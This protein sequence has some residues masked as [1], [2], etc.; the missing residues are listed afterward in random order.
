MAKIT[1]V[2]P[3]QAHMSGGTQLVVTGSGFT[4]VSRVFFEDRNFRQY[5]AQFTVDSTTQITLTSPATNGH[6][7]KMHVFVVA[8]GQE[9][10]VAQ[11]PVLESDGDHLSSAGTGGVNWTTEAGPAA[12]I[13]VVGY[14]QEELKEA[15]NAASAAS[16]PISLNLSREEMDAIMRQEGLTD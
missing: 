8:N 9:N 4:N 14:T 7:G 2:S 1:S 13:Q 15:L 10:T 16:Q 3:R 11:V 6:D 5:D 12:Q